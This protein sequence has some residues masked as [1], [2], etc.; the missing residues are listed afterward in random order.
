MIAYCGVSTLKPI[1]KIAVRANALG[2]LGSFDDGLAELRAEFAANPDKMRSLQNAISTGQISSDDDDNDDEH[3][4][5][6]QHPNAADGGNPGA[7]HHNGDDDDEEEDDDAYEARMLARR[8][9]RNSSS[10]CFGSSSD[11]N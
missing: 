2:A 4:D 7:Q 6:A 9:S 5:G 8:N 1:S 11:M 3:D 10:V